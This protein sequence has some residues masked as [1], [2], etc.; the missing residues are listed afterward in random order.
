MRPQA[1]AFGDRGLSCH[2][3]Y[4]LALFSVD[5]ATADGHFDK[6]TSCVVGDQLGWLKSS[7]TG[8]VLIMNGLAT[9]STS[10]GV[11]EKGA[12]GRGVEQHNEDDVGLLQHSCWCRRY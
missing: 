2:D 12:Y 8:L 11:V 6:V 7:G 10:E 1:D 9:K 4:E 3:A 5:I